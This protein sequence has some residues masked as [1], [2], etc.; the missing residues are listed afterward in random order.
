MAYAV[1]CFLVAG[2]AWY[3]TIANR[4]RASTIEE[5]FLGGRNIS[6]SLFQNATWGTSFAFNN[7]IY[8]GIF[9]GYA[10]GLNALW[11]NGSWALGFVGLSFLLPR[12]VAPT[13]RFTLHGFLGDKFGPRVRIMASIAS[14]TVMIFNIGAE[15][16]FASIF[17]SYFLGSPALEVAIAIVIAIFSASFVGVGG[18]RANAAIDTY[19]NMLSAG[20]LAFLI[21]LC[22]VNASVLS[23]PTVLIVSLMSL[24]PLLVYAILSIRAPSEYYRY[25]LACLLGTAAFS[26]LLVALVFN[27]T[28][29]VAA[30]DTGKLLTSFGPYSGWYMASVVVFQFAYQFVDTSN[31]QNI[32]ARRLTLLPI[33]SGPNSEENAQRGVQDT[34]PAVRMAAGL[35][36]AAVR[37]FLAPIFLATLLGIAFKMIVPES[38]S[39]DATF[40]SIW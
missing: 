12:L 27:N 39:T 18:Y 20:A 28:G 38:K 3:I 35:R 9:F 23:A 11:V 25:E 8:W 33:E 31:W 34:I 21:C 37:I 19:Q 17:I 14:S 13:E 5:F 10:A 22:A 26:S 2:F 1:I 16:V 30:F 29:G 6:G 24:L 36:V 32:S 40:R 15:I 4:N 7:G